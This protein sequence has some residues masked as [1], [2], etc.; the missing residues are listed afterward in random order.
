MCMFVLESHLSIHGI[1]ISFIG[2]E[3]AYVLF[4]TWF[5]MLRTKLSCYVDVGEIDG[6]YNV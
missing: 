4:S 3:C 5:F 1:V 2:D 6:Q